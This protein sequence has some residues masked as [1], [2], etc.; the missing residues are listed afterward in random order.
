M[1]FGSKAKRSFILVL[2][3]IFVMNSF[4]LHADSQSTANPIPILGDCNNDGK[5]TIDDLVIVA[6]HFISQRGD[7]RYDPEADVNNDGYI[8]AVDVGMMKA[9]YGKP[10]PAPVPIVAVAGQDFVTYKLFNAAL[11]SSQSYIAPG[12]AVSYSWRLIEKPQGSSAVLSNE[13]SANSSFVPDVVG[14]YKVGLTINDG[15]YYSRESVMNVTVKEIGATT[16]TMDI[17]SIGTGKSLSSPYDYTDMIPLSDGWVITKDKVN[18]KVLFYNTLLGIK[19]KE[20]ST[21]TIG[22][23]NRMDIDFERNLLYVSIAGINKIAQINLKTDAVTYLSVN[24]PATEIAV[25]ENSILF[26]ISNNGSSNY[27][28]VLDTE[29]K[30]VVNSIQQMDSYS[31][32]VYDKSGN[33]LILGE[34]GY[35]P[36]SLESYAFD[37][38]AF[39]LKQSKYL[40]DAGSNGLDL[41][42]SNDGQHIAFSCGSGNGRSYTIFDTSSS[43][44]TQHTGEWNTDAYPTSASFSLD[45]RYLIA[46]NGFYIEIFNRESHEL[47]NKFARRNSNSYDKVNISRGG[48]IIYDAIGQRLDIFQSGLEQVYVAPPVVSSKPVGIIGR[49][50]VTFQ[51]FNV[52]LDGSRSRIVEGNSLTYNWAIE[53]KPESSQAALTNAATAK[54]SF[55]SDQ[56]GDYR[57]SLVVNNSIE[58]SDKKYI[59]IK[60]KDIS[61]TTDDIDPSMVSSLPNDNIS[62]YAYVKPVALSDGWMIAADTNNN[63]QVVNILAGDIGKKYQL[64]AAPTSIDFDFEQKR[65][66]STMANTNKI[67]VIN[68]SN[69]SVSYIDTPT[70]YTGITYGEDNVA[71]AVSSGEV[72]IIDLTQKTIL[73]RLNEYVYNANLI[74]YDKNNNNLF[75]AEKGLSP[76]SLFR[77]SYNAATKQLAK[78]QEFSYGSNGIDLTL[79][80]DGKHVAFSCGGGNG[81]YGYKIFDIDSADIS[82][83]LGEWDTGA[84]PTSAVFTNDNNYMI[85]SNGSSLKLFEVST[86]YFVTNIGGVNTAGSYDKVFISRGDKLIYDMAGNVVKFL[87]N[88]WTIQQ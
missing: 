26:V 15:Q 5:V 69:D 43:D 83:K 49:D 64:L 65:I 60:V 45:D 25:G 12:R 87:F 73:Q 85:A 71:F 18:K 77:F 35:S 28:Q 62:G 48:R 53:A 66:I 76:S 70:T 17:S 50:R 2:T 58:S 86:H 39:F 63:I 54:P 29:S 84:Y 55:V 13:T 16:D 44:I 4:I 36:S 30:A 67:A 56:I 23:P 75:V 19:G 3:L 68:I 72:S 7:M 9:N 61:S 21:S 22:V 57:L 41:A 27:L 46:S 32:M 59:N 10:D 31:L 24:G 74:E 79:S 11:D 42:I 52:Q 78:Q 14:V 8:N 20:Y 33:N 34:T 37:S 81:S 47:I 38:E 40:W 51:G 82:K 80:N 6:L 1:Y 88:S